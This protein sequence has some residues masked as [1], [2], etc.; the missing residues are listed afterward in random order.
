MKTH[1]EKKRTWEESQE[2]CNKHKASLVAIE[3]QEDQSNL[4]TFL[5]QFGRHDYWTSGRRDSSGK[6][7][8]INNGNEIV[9][10]NWY[11]GDPNGGHEN[12]IAFIGNNNDSY[13]GKW[14]DYDCNA[15]LNIFCELSLNI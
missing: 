12:C 7:K 13:N 14:G 3:S 1:G 10:T 11:P 6:Y 15:D 4:Q 9:Y 5:G 2:I 8:W